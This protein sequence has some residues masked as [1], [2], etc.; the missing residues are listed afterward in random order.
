VTEPDP[1]HQPAAPRPDLGDTDPT[2]TPA[3]VI[4][5]AAAGT[6][7]V[8][9]L[10]VYSFLFI[11]RGL[12]VQVEQ[13]DITSS[14]TGEAIAGFIALV[15]LGIVAWGIVRLLNG[16]NR[17][18]F[19]IGQLVTAVAAARFLLDSS[20]GEPQVPAVMLVAAVL[21][22]LF[23]AL[24][25]ATRW[26]RTGGGEHPPVTRRTKPD[27]SDDGGLLGHSVGQQG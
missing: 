1:P 24:P 3:V 10:I 5:A 11:V 23:S 6:V 19:W 2:A 25:P 17:L 21:A 15:F 12:F 20:S 27:M 7:V 13:P 22:L 14:R 9:F 4:A 8:P 26:V 16:Q 18:V